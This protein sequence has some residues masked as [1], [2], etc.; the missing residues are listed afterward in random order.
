MKI[1]GGNF[2]RK[3]P[4]SERI[5]KIN[6][7]KFG[8]IMTVIEYYHSQDMWI[9][10][11]QGKP[12]HTNWHD[13]SKGTI[14]NP[15][16]RTVCGVGYLGEGSHVASDNGK[17]SRCYITWND[18]FKRCYDAKFHEKSPTYKECLVCSE[19][20]N[21]QNFADWY[22]ENYY[23]VD[24]ERMEIDKDILVKGN[25]VYS[26]ET[27]I[28]VPRKINALFVKSNAKR[29]KLPIGVRSSQTNGKYTVR[30]LDGSKN[31]IYIGTFNSLSEAFQEYKLHKEYVIRKIADE[32]KS[33]IP[34][35]LYDAMVNYE[36]SITD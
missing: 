19:W 26:P 17:Q 2:L 34:N 5:G 35:E 18:I 20:H 32:Y 4:S 25:K 27:C 23:Q 30:C 7:N 1:K 11:E 36:I 14:K 3:I 9:K 8:S 28:F 31:E 15:Y 29:G 13:F 12:I 33:K 21:F 24:G 16:D 22:D 6:K 10:F